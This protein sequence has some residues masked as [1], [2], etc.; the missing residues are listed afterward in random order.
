MTNKP[1]TPLSVAFPAKGAAEPRP[2]L[3]PLPGTRASGEPG[4][5]VATDQIEAAVPKLKLDRK[6][7]NEY[8]ALTIRPGPERRKRLEQVSTETGHSMQDI[9]LACFD[10]FYPPIKID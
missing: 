1:R 10:A 3:S 6:Q 2:G 5:E 8:A 4:P 9:L 7:K